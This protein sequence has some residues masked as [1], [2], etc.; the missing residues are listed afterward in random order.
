MVSRGDT[1]GDDFPIGSIDE[2]VLAIHVVIVRKVSFLDL[3]DD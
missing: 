3:T 2:S 1:Y